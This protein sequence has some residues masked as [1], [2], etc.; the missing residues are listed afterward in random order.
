MIDNYA[1][2]LLDDQTLTFHYFPH[3]AAS[4]TYVAMIGH[5]PYP[6]DARRFIQFCSVGRP[7]GALGYQHR[8]NTRL[9]PI[10]E[11]HRVRQ[12]RQLLSEPSLN[13]Q[14]ILQRQR[15]V[16]KLFDAMAFVCR[17]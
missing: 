8:K 4:P 10:R 11:I 1:N 9:S 13:Y 5:N 12:Q 3:S 16:P 7:T 2:L 14:L 6:A 15:L 17:S